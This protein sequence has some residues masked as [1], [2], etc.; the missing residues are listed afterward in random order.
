MPSTDPRLPRPDRRRQR[1]IRDLQRTSTLSWAEATAQVDLEHAARTSGIDIARARLTIV[2]PPV[3]G[4][5]L[6]SWRTTQAPVLITVEDPRQPNPIEIHLQGPTPAREEL[7]RLNGWLEVYLALDQHGWAPRSREP[8]N[9]KL[10]VFAVE[11]NARGCADDEWTR[12]TTSAGLPTDERA[13][14]GYILAVHDALS[15]HGFPARV[16]DMP[17]DGI[18]GGVRSASMWLELPPEATGDYCEE[19]DARS[20]RPRRLRRRSGVRP[21]G[22]TGVRQVLRLAVPLL[23][24]QRRPAHPRRARPASRNRAAASS[25]STGPTRRGCSPA[26]PSSKPLCRLGPPRKSCHHHGSTTAQATAADRPAARSTSA[27]PGQVL[28]WAR[29]GTRPTALER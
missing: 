20:A 2:E 24:D 14:E 28:E 4:D 5:D 21:R 25:G 10:D 1:E 27:V 29:P 9:R 16:R 22:P 23:P 19:R 11:R 12:I 8:G 26:A 6:A 7:D 3:T 13:A 15:Q 17:H 18:A